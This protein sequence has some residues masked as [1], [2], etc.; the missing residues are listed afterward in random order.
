MF[1][2]PT[3]HSMHWMPHLHCNIAILLASDITRDEIITFFPRINICIK[4]IRYMLDV[5]I[6]SY[7]YVH[8]DFHHV[9]RGGNFDNL[10]ALYNQIEEAIQKQGYFLMNSKGE[11][12]LEQS[13]VVRS[14]CI[15]CLDRTN[16][17]QSFLARKSLDSQ[18]QKM[19]ALSSSESISIS[20]SIN[21]I[22]KKLWIEHGDELS[23]EYAGSYALKGDLV[24]YGRQTLPG[25]IKDG[26]SALSRYYLNNFHDGVRQDA[27]DL[28]SGYYTVSQGS[29]SPFHT[30][31]FESASYLPVASAI[32]VGGIT[33]TTF[34][35]SQV[36]RNA[37][38][39]I[40]PIIC[41]GLTVGVAALVKANGKQFCSR[42]R[43]CGLI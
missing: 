28:I 35:L 10:Q 6:P 39:F 5:A 22:F 3:C 36:G 4:C 2:G 12:L 11:I 43:L 26:M 30:G 20:D 15:D 7:R 38:H 31:G 32:I 16:V 19:G 41:A 14:N 37:Q 17:T 18:L 1:S 25:L 42:P 23:L 13:G 34:T 21:D 40:S 27:L 8:F 33:A 29:S 24:R 9:C